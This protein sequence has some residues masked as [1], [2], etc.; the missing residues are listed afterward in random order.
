MEI[1]WLSAAERPFLDVPEDKEEKIGPETD[2]R[3]RGVPKVTRVELVD[4]PRYL[5][6]KKAETILVEEHRGGYVYFALQG[7]LHVPF[8][9]VPAGAASGAYVNVT[10]RY[11][12]KVP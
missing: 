4:Y 5:A 8:A 2:Y 7:V 9:E 12:A 3:L 1:T 10:R 6:E 11:K